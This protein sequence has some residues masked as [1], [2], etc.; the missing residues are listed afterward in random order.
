MDLPPSPAPPVIGTGN[1]DLP[2]QKRG[3]TLEE[4]V[5]ITTGMDML[6]PCLGNTGEI[7]RFGWKGLCLQ[8]SPLGV[9]L[10]DFA[11]A[12]PAGVRAAA[13]R[14]AAGGR[15]WEGFDGDPFL[16]GAATVVTIEGYQSVGVIDIANEQE[17]YRGGSSASQ[18]SSSNIDDRTMHELPGLPLAFC[19]GRQADAG[20]PEQQAYQW[21]TEGELG[22]QGCRTAGCPGPL[23]SH[24]HVLGSRA[25]GDSGANGSVP[26]ARL[27]DMVIRT[28]GAWYKVG[29]D[30]DYPAVDLPHVNCGSF[31][32]P[33]SLT[34]AQFLTPWISR[35]QARLTSYFRSCPPP[36]NVQ[37]DH[38]KLIR[39]IGAAS[40]ILLK[41]AY[42]T[43]PLEVKN[44]SIGISA[45]TR[46]PNP[47]G[48]NGCTEYAKHCWTKA[49]GVNATAS[50]SV[51]PAGPSSVGNEVSQL[52]LGF[53]SAYSEP[54]KVLRGFARTMLALEQTKTVTI[55]LGQ[56]DQLVLASGTFK[57]MVGSLSH[58]IHLEGTFQL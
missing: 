4:K 50:T 29:Q 28:L 2:S 18:I 32:L 12:F 34:F 19:R 5:N 44:V 43:L 48:P 37:A 35:A 54:P 7:S 6:G 13:S 21:D 30:R 45:P 53:P 38:H 23:K 20:V 52:Y 24:E 26:M 27:D 56:K 25:R 58:A 39:K 40:T 42:R 15:N 11:S 17:H 22:F 9:R 47:D 57:V 36:N 3:L 41:N 14:Q 55:P 46:G 49:A 10:A 1:G 33:P 16:A 51:L 31:S 8:D